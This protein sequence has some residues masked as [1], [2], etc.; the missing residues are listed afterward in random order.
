MS[1]SARYDEDEA[2]SYD[3]EEM[4]TSS[5]PIRDDAEDEVPR[6]SPH[7]AQAQPFQSSALEF[8]PFT[9]V[10]RDFIQDLYGRIR[11]R[12]EVFVDQWVD[13]F[14]SSFAADEEED[15]WNGVNSEQALD[16]DLDDGN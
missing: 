15:A 1:P 11:Y 4:N 2:S 5:G 7:I 8:L 14:I 9:A 16:G 10:L 12:V 3:G 6:R 13:W